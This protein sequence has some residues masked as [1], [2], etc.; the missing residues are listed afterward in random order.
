MP[1]KTYTVEIDRFKVVDEN[2]NIYTLLESQDILETSAHDGTISTNPGKKYLTILENGQPV[3]FIEDGRYY[4]P[5]P[6]LYLT[7]L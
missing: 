6:E 2:G 4:A 7:M 3:N 1:T 5:G